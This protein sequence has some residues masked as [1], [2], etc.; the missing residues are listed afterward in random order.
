MT[1]K[2][3]AKIQEESSKIR[4]YQSKDSIR[5][6]FLKNSK[7][8]AIFRFLTDGDSLI[9]AQFHTVEETTSNGKTIWAKY[10][11]P[12]QDGVPCKWHAAGNPT[13]E[14][15]YLWVYWKC[16]LHTT[17]NPALDTNPDA[18][19]W[20]RGTFNGMPMYKEEL[21]IP[22]IYRTSVGKSGIYKR[23]LINY[24]NKY[25]SFLDRDYEL[26]RE[27]K[28]KET[29]YMLSPRDPTAMDPT[30]KELISTLPDLEKVVSGKITS[31][32]QSEEN[33]TTAT[34]QVDAVEETSEVSNTE[35]V[36]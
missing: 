23:T 21:N 6:V 5:S 16:T 24:Y 32:N 25:G 31:F 27:G 12:E 15:L 10:Y 28:N 3:V 2:G 30:I 33:K 34:E 1:I 9:S 8:V 14:L 36:F 22:A 19:S 20:P 4:E 13:S 7:D 29:L 11:C 35:E 26:L 17:Q 18:K